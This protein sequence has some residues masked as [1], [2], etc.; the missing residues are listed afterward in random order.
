MAA[1]SHTPGVAAKTC[2][3]IAHALLLQD[4]GHTR[5]KEDVFALATGEEVVCDPAHQRL[6]CSGMQLMTNC[7]SVSDTL[8][9]HACTAAVL[10]SSLLAP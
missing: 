2:T 9:G 10:P 8:Q 5:Q 4:M 7:R 1:V 6:G 3:L